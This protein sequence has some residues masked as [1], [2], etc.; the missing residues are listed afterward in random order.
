[1]CFLQ[2]R[3]GASK[4]K[5]KNFWEVTKFMGVE[6]NNYRIGEQ[7]NFFLVKIIKEDLRGFNFKSRLFNQV[8]YLFVAICRLVTA[9]ERLS[10]IEKRD[11]SS[12]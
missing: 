5:P 10:E 12:R 7:V 1:M 4:I 3:K 9:V 11:I 8:E 2:V 6:F